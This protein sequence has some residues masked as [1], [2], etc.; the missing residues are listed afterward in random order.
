MPAKPNAFGMIVA[1]GFP[2]G[3]NA[4]PSWFSSASNLPG[5]Q[6]MSTFF[7][8]AVPT[9][10]RSVIGFRLGASAMMRAHVKS[11]V[12]PTVQTVADPWGKCVVDRR[13]AD[14]ALDSD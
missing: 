10:S 3:R 4:F 2:S 7:T 1:A 8:V 9:P 13:M 12:A 14:G 11:P 6:L 5:P